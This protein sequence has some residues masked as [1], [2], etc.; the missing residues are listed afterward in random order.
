TNPQ[1]RFVFT[2]VQPGDALL[3]AIYGKKTAS[4]FVRLNPGDNAADLALDE[5][6]PRPPADS[7]NDNEIVVEYTQQGD[8][9][10]QRQQKAEGVGATTATPSV[11]YE[12]TG[13]KE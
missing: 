5:L 7:V 9:Q 13:K 6:A 11:T 8:G 4:R 3:I 1:G 10:K 12:T 2:N